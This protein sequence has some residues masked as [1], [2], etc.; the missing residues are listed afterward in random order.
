MKLINFLEDATLNSFRRTMGAS[1]SQFKVVIKLP[2][3]IAKEEPRA[4]IVLPLPIEGLE[5]DGTEIVTHSDNT[6]LYKNKRVL[7]HILDST[8]HLPRFHLAN[9]MTLIEMKNAGRFER[10][11]VSEREDGFFHIRM[12]GG[13]LTQTKLP[14]C[15]NC[16]DRL[17]WK[18]FSRESMSS[19]SRQIAVSNFSI[20]EFFSK[21]PHSLHSATPKHTDKSSPKN[22]YP[23]N[24]DLISSELRRQ[25]G[26]VCQSCYIVVGEANKGYLHVHHINGVRSDCRVENL[27]CLCISCHADQPMHEHMKDS[28]EYQEF[29]KLRAKLIS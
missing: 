2:P 21:Y 29:K 20:K 19:P 22:E 25:L 4:A 13:P 24:W 1:L 17:S 18:G 12:N 10:Y 27:K 14:V 26:Y 7:I 23:V 8:Q 3:V 6:L 11:V 9:C 5:V 28:S 15:Q 16:L